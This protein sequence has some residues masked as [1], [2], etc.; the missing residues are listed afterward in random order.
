MSETPMSG[1]HLVPKPQ[2][3]PSYEGDIMPECRLYRAEIFW[4][5]LGPWL[6][7]Q[8]YLLRPRYRVNWSA[9]WKDND[10]DWSECED[11]QVPMVLHIMDATRISDGAIVMLKK[12]TTSQHPNEVEIGQLFSSEPHLSDSRNHCVPT[13]DILKIPGDDDNVLIVMPHL[14]VAYAPEFSTIGETVEFFRQIFEGLQFMHNQHIAH[15]D[16]KSDNIMMD[17]KNLYRELVHPVDPT[18][19]R[20]FRRRSKA[21]TRLERPVN[22]FLIDFGLSCRYQSDDPKPLGEPHVGGDRTVP[23][24]AAGLP[25]NPFQADVYCIGNIVRRLTEHDPLKEFPARRGFEFMRSLVSDMVQDEPTKRPTM[26][27]V[28]SRFTAIRSKLSWW[29]LRSR[30]VR[31]DENPIAGVFRSIS[32]W[33]KQTVLIINRT[34]AL[35]IPPSQR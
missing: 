8:G 19:T 34:P 35:P 16:C 32:H 26:D 15:R 2:L 11:G 13:Y 18:R 1:S 31:R 20:D 17:S 33:A 27:E 28:V 6:E 10:K 30:F 12:V 24:F 4:R 23:E 9:S 29:K 22:Y 21:L 7:M 14:T 25:V 3:H 5:D